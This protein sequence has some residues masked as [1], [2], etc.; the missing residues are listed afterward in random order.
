MKTSCQFI[1]NLLGFKQNTPNHQHTE[2]Q[3]L[4]IFLQGFSIEVMPK[5]LA[6]VDKLSDILPS[7]TRIY[8]AHIEGTAFQDT[9]ASAK[10]IQ[11]EGYIAMPHIPARTIKNK[12]ELSFWLQ[13]YSDIGVN[14]ALLLAGGLNSPLGKFTNSLQLLETGLFDYHNFQRIHIAGHPENN[15]DIDPDGSDKNV[16]TALKWKANFAERSDAQFAITTQFCFDSAPVIKWAHRLQQEKIKLPI[17]LGIAGPSKL[18]TLLKYAMICG[19][20]PSLKVL[21][22]QAMNAS[23]LLLPIEPNNLLVQLSLYKQSHP[24][25]PIEALHFFPLGGIQASANWIQ[26]YSKTT[27]H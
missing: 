17:H 7:K 4:S 21:Q 15:K 16:M 2:Q 14:Q 20:G 25:F 12:A 6:K 23:K 22:R 1:K 26:K 9:L 13:A 10:R 19:I 11:A 27:Q 18:Q 5:T 8:I 24:D 3:L